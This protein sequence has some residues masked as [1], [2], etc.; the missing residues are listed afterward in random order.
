M[1]IDWLIDWLMST[2]TL[3]YGQC[4]LHQYLVFLFD[5]G[6][7]VGGSRGVGFLVWSIP[8]SSPPKTSF[9][10]TT[11]RIAM[12]G[13]AAF[14]IA[15]FGIRRDPWYKGVP[16]LHKRVTWPL[17]DPRWPNFA[18]CSLVPLVVYMHA[19]FEVSSF[20]RF[21]DMEGVPKFQK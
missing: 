10:I 21:R 7:S 3:L 15:T 18:F 2:I 5:L 19:K 11:F 8:P 14:G 1:C 20:N 9:G 12:F 16:K 6:L 4:F 13:I 17:Y